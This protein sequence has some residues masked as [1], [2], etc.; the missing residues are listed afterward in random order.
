M[1]LMIEE[2][3]APIRE[4]EYHH[5]ANKHKAKGGLLPVVQTNFFQPQLPFWCSE[6]KQ[7]AKEELSAV[8]ECLINIMFSSAMETE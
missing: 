3:E 5:Q 1:S 6:Q 2:L 8:P 4:L 7:K